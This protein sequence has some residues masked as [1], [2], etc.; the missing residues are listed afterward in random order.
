ME[1]L[2]RDAGVDNCHV[3]VLIARK[4]GRSEYAS[5]SAAGEA[6]PS[7]NLSDLEHIA[8]NGGEWE[9]LTTVVYFFKHVTLL[10]VKGSDRHHIQV[11][12]IVDELAAEIDRG[13]RSLPHEGRLTWSLMALWALMLAGSFGAQAADYD[14]LD[15]ILR[16]ASWMPWIGFVS[17]GIVRR[18]IVPAREII[19]EGEQSRASRWGRPLLRF[20]G[21]VLTLALGAV[22]G[23]IVQRWI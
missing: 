18:I 4:G 1:T 2:L 23:A 14:R 8:L 15:D 10:T 17:L 19:P 20:G 12:G 6:L 22:L 11:A 5:A 16:L 21:W 3:N 7:A 9:K 13:S